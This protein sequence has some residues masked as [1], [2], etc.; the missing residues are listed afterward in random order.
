MSTHS[1]TQSGASVEFFVR[2]HRIQQKT[3]KT[4]RGDLQNSEIGVSLQYHNN[5][6]RY[7]FLVFRGE[8][9]IYSTIRE[10]LYVIFSTNLMDTVI[11]EVQSHIVGSRTM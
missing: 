1:H 11:G 4:E 8:M 5:R 6:F 3:G 7:G 9:A 10:P 2:L